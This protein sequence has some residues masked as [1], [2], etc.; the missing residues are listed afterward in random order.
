VHRYILTPAQRESLFLHSIELN[1]IFI[2][3]NRTRITSKKRRLLLYAQR[4]KC[5]YCT[6]FIDE[7]QSHLEH[8][9]PFRYY[10]NETEFVLT[11]IPC[12]QAKG[13]KVWDTKDFFIIR[14]KVLELRALIGM[15]RP[16]GVIEQDNLAF[17]EYKKQKH[18]ADLMDKL[19]GKHPKQNI[20]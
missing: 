5:A 17:I 3:M 11:C 8:V 6:D 1:A 14:E 2:I 10:G 13:D 15:F 18:S 19:Y 20:L 16:Q 9:L 4:N 7:K 12:N